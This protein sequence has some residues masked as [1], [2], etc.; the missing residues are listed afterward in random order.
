MKYEKIQFP[1]RELEGAKI[2]DPSNE[3]YTICDFYFETID[4]KIL[5]LWLQIYDSDYE[6]SNINYLEICR[7]NSGWKIISGRFDVEKLKVVNYE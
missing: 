7:K 4:F 5:S 3:E 6:T 1:L 2:V